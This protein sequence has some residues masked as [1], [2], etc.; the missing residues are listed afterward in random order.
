MTLSDSPMGLLRAGALAVAQLSDPRLRAPL[1]KSVGLTLAAFLTL[2]TGIGWLIAN[3]RFFETGWLDIGA[4][5]LGGILAVLLSVVLFPSVVA[6]FLGVFLEDVAAAVD[7][8]HYPGLPAPAK[9][10]PLAELAGALRLVATAVALN[11]LV[12]PLYLVPGLNLAVF[13]ATNGF[14]LAREYVTMS[15]ARR[16][17]SHDARRLWRDRRGQAWLAG[18]AFAALSTIPVVNLAAPVVAVATTTHLIEAWRRAQ[19]NRPSAPGN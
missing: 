18:A 19:A 12:L 3:T 13:L 11:L 16:L 10:H 7:A 1:L 4:G 14:L 15:A 17:D 8:R 9:R 2:W 6:A 5:A